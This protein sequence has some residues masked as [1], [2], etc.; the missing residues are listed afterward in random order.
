MK[1]AAT[2]LLLPS[3]RQ[4]GMWRR[5][6]WDVV[7]PLFGR[8]RETAA[9][10]DAAEA[11]PTPL[12]GGYVLQVHHSRNSKQKQWDETLVKAMRLLAR[13]L[14]ARRPLCWSPSLPGSAPL[15]PKDRLA[16]VWPHTGPQLPFLFSFRS[17]SV[18]PKR[19]KGHLPVLAELEGFS[20]RWTALSAIQLDCIVSGS[21]EVRGFAWEGESNE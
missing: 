3:L 7:F 11:G 2:R 17:S 6:L 9:H 18:E 16:Y 14:K 12:G 19:I 5:C 10:A 20:V 15:S 21:R 13:V 1:I 8:V 4:V